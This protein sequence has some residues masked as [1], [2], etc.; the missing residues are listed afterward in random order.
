MNRRTETCIKI[1]D[2]PAMK[3]LT[4]SQYHIDPHPRF[5]GGDAFITFTTTVRGEVDLAMVKVAD[6]VDATT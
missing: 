3:G 4:G 6:L 2:N 5:C 1:I